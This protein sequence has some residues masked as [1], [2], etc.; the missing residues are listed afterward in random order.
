MRAS[1][2]K[3][4]DQPSCTVSRNTAWKKT[5]LC[6]MAIMLVYLVAAYLSLGRFGIEK[7][8]TGFAMP[9][10][11]GW[12]ALT[13]S[14]A[15]SWFSQTTPISRWACSI[16]WFIL[17]I[18]STSPLPSFLMNDL[19]SQLIEEYQPSN[20]PDLDAL[21]VLGGGTV[22]GPGRPEAGDAG[23]RVL[24]AA[25]LYAQGKAKRLITTGDQTS[26]ETQAM[27]LKLGI[28]ADDIIRLPGA[29]TFQEIGNIR[30]HLY[31]ISAQ[32][33]GILSSAYHLPRAQRLAKSAG[34]DN[35][36]SVAANHRSGNSEYDVLDFL[37]SASNLVRFSDAY[38]EF[39]GRAVGR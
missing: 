6:M 5:L 30:T 36:I 17:T 11:L 29:N 26:D 14:A 3:S 4:Q 22:S 35:L 39:L 33:V 18:C 2:C 24:Y 34:L 16:A 15:Y 13:A 25:E 20:D 27:W 10:G 8:L 9:L 21:I 7:V 19:E 38:K 1:D 31:Q 32:R 37:P 12:L 23:D 28:P